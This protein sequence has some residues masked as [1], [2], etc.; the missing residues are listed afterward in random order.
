MLPAGGPDQL[1]CRSSSRTSRRPGPA[2]RARRC[3]SSARFRG[4]DSARAG[5][6]RTPST[7][8]NSSG[9]SPICRRARSGAASGAPEDR[10]QRPLP[11]PRSPAS[12]RS[13]SWACHRRRHRRGRGIPRANRKPDSTHVRSAFGLAGLRVGQEAGSPPPMSAARCR[14]R[15]PSQRPP[16]FRGRHTARCRVPRAAL[17]TT[18]A[19]VGSPGNADAKAPG[20][21][22]ARERRAAPHSA[23]ARTPPRQ[24]GSAETQLSASVSVRRRRRAASAPRLI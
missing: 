16:P 8:R 3:Q 14:S 7:S 11:G 12:R 1:K 19:P 23:S 24:R 4:A 22:S 20:D 5:S 15:P 2:R 6:T 13:S 21:H 17:A 18:R 9:R 10:A